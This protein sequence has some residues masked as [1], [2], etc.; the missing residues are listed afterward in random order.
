MQLRPS[1]YRATALALTLAVVVAMPSASYA[2]TNAIFTIA[3]TGVAGFSGGD[4]TLAVAAQLNQPYSVSATP[5]GGFL[6]ADFANNRV[7]RV[8]ALGTITTVAGNGTAGYSGDDGPATLAK[9]YGPASVSATADGGFLIAEAYNHRIRRVSPAGTITTVAG[10]LGAGY[11]G[12]GGPATTAK[13]LY[14]FA[15]AATPDGGFLVADTYNHRIRRVSPA[16]TIT[17]IAGVGTSGFS[18]DDRLATTAKLYYPFGV[19]AAAG[20][21]VLIADTYNNRIRRV[22]PDGTITTIAGNASVGFI[23]G[24]PATS[25]SLYR[26]FG[27]A[28]LADGGFLIADTYNHRIRRVSP[29]GTI[30][31]VAGTGTAGF[32]SDGG[33]ATAAQINYAYGVA[34]T[35]DGGFL[36]PDR[37]NHRVRFVDSDLRPAPVPTATV[38][39]SATSPSSPSADHSV[40]GS[41]TTSEQPRAFTRLALALTSDR[42][43][44]KR[45]RRGRIRYVVTTAGS[46]WLDVLRG[47]SVVTSAQGRARTGH[48]ALTLTRRGLAPGRYRLRL[49][50][51]TS[52]GQLASDFARLTIYR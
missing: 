4:G 30:S 41:Q 48:N 43:R 26:P 45:N 14:P 29:S 38:A 1:T 10:G 25:A 28:S 2:A 46:V 33:P 13:L 19:A 6:L 11:G 49:R 12:D 31:T 35:A 51:R 52:D 5:D 23:G 39:P 21:S 17:T 36:I 42:L 50:A 34:T 8:S 20:G 32:S 9:L 3:G 18:D 7:R 44:L 27:I 37:Q 15:V 16:G 24:G 47:K 22:T 40:L